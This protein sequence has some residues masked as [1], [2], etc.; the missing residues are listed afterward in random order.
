MCSQTNETALHEAVRDCRIETIRELLYENQCDPHIV[1]MNGRTAAFMFFLNLLVKGNINGSDACLTTDQIAC[2]TD[3]LWFTY[4]T[5]IAMENERMEVFDMIDYCFQFF[6]AHTYR[7]LYMEIVNVFITPS[8]H[9]RYFVENIREANL[10]S[11]YCLI[12]SMFPMNELLVDG[13]FVNL[14]SNFLSEALTLF[15]VNE[16]L[17]GEYISE[18]MSTGWT[19][20]M[21]DQSKAFCS[22]LLAINPTIPMLFN[23][24]KYVIQYEIGFSDLLYFCAIDGLDHTICDDIISNVFVPLSN[25]SNVSI[26]LAR[27]LRQGR[28]NKLAYYNFDETGY[29]SDDFN[30]FVHK[31]KNKEVKNCNFNQVVSLQNLARMNIRKYYFKKYS[32]Y[33]ALSLL[34]SLN[35]PI[36]IRKF[37]CYNQ[38]NLKF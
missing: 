1:D 38:C 37:V 11:D 24:M 20:K 3:M 8:H 28:P 15:I 6:D 35:V 36:I 29:L 9:R 2:Y 26:D 21:E 16:S 25:F 27:L 30:V 33:K 13:N 18:V 12:A 22:T 23:F 4:D 32:H 34:Y 19:L 14:K 10:Y 5:Q 7:K 17:F 31:I